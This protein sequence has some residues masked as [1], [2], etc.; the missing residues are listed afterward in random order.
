MLRR[1]RSTEPADGELAALAD[2][3]LAPERR[4][5]L[6]A[7]VAMS[8]ELA[9]ELADQQRA[10]ALTR[11]AVA[12][13]EA[14]A[15]LRARVEAQRRSPRSAPTRRLAL[16][17][18]GATIVVAT[19]A[20]GLAVMLSGSS[21]S[22]EQF[23]AALGPTGAVPGASGEATLKE[24]PSGWRVTLHAAGLPHLAHGR[25][26]EAW[27]RNPGGVL[28]PIGTFNDG[29]NVTLW[30]GVEPKDSWTLTVTRER[31]DGN[32]ASSGDKVLAGSVDVPAH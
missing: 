12:D 18:A 25:F 19:A 26:Y 3:S 13:V 9:D 4:E 32:Q 24:T 23:A 30:S 14:P 20:V 15:G 21:S 1:R 7:R 29:R 5:A 16:A 8:T 27:L 22:G 31:A 10:V 17:A 11:S 6:A 28:V 2:G